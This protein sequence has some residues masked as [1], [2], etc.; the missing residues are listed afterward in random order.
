MSAKLEKHLSSQRKNLDVESPDDDAIWKG[1]Q[2]GLHKEKPAVKLMMGKSRMIKIRN[3]AA[4][5]F[6]LFSL[7]Y[8]AN[9][10]INGKISDRRITLSSID[11]ELGRREKEYKTL[12]SFKTKEVRSFTGPRDAVIKE[13]FKEINK[14][15]PIYDQALKDLK[16]DLYNSKLDAA[17]T[18]NLKIESK[19]TKVNALSSG[20]LEIN[21]YND[22]YSIPK[23][24][25]ITFTAK[26]SD[27]KTESSGQII[28]DCYEGT[29]VMK[30]V[31]DIKITSK[32][33]DFQFGI[34]EDIS[35]ASSY[36][37]KMVADKLN[38]LRINE[39]KYCSYRMDELVSSVTEGDGYEDK[40]SIMKT[41]QE[42]KEIKVNG[43]YVDVSLSLPK[44]TD[45]RFKAKITYPKLDMDESLFKT[46]I[47]VSEGSQLEYDAIRGTEKDGM[48]LIEI[49]G[50]Q[51]SLKIIGI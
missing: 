28:L 16:A 36:S 25:D 41:G 4:A 32:Y 38:S 20:S 17:N 49:N 13:L 35:V 9:D 14:L 29:V 8:I 47:K 46:K 11:S 23:T 10:I 22:K 43:K 7:G 48:P 27:L 51:M 45:F 30:E 21:S 24:G 26:Y 5:A 19:Y 50:Y 39:S 42:F 1:I 3:I 31:K 15:D 2:R 33:A 34:A 6:I 18:G 37:D 44:T 12:V 40:F